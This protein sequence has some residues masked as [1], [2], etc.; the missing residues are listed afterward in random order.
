MVGGP[1]IQHLGDWWSSVN[2]GSRQG[3][4]S[5][6]HSGN[7][8]STAAREG[9]GGG[10]GEAVSSRTWNIW[11]RVRVPVFPHIPEHHGSSSP[12]ELINVHRLAL[13]HPRYW[14]GGRQHDP[15]SSL[16]G[17]GNDPQQTETLSKETFPV[18]SST[19]FSAKDWKTHSAI[20]QMPCMV[21]CH[22][23]H[24][25]Q[26]LGGLGR[27]WH[28]KSQFSSQRDFSFS[29]NFKAS[30]CL[31]SISDIN[32]DTG[33]MRWP[34]AAPSGRGVVSNWNRLTAL[35]SYLE[36]SIITLNLNQHDSRPFFL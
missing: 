20:L 6:H 26:R 22:L 15:L 32:R 2:K 24:W 16:P 34:K 5:I 30:R 23:F 27:N 17:I 36:G 35:V 9:N 28:P 12:G 8:T 31:K 21:V 13:P 19:F 14:V 11:Q 33:K 3:T 18:Y 1:C 10:T 7:P 29:H 4:W 25:C